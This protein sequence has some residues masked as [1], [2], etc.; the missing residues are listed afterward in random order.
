MENGG[1][2]KATVTKIQLV[3]LKHIFDPPLC[4]FLVIV[5]LPW[6]IVLTQPFRYLIPLPPKKAPI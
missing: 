5:D 1:I 6:D 3:R 2:G 4:G